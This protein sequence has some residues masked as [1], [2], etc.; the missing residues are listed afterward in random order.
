MT[1]LI[2]TL[3]GGNSMNAYEK[4][5]FEDVILRKL[6]R[7]LEKPAYQELSKEQDALQKTLED[8][9]TGAQKKLLRRQQELGIRMT[10]MEMELVFQETLALSR[11]LLFPVSTDKTPC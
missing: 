6:D 9:I 5:L 3:I 1:N 11:A 10:S 2:K 4:S 8:G 7:I